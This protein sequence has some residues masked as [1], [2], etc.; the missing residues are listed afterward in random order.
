MQ[1]CYYPDILLYKI[2]ISYQEEEE[3]V[4]LSVDRVETTEDMT[5]DPSSAC[6][7]EEKSKPS[8]SSSKL[9][10][11]IDG[12]LKF[13]SAVSESRQK[14]NPSLL[15]NAFL[16]STLPS[17]ISKALIS[18]SNDK[19]S[20]STPC[21]T[22]STSTTTTDQELVR[23]DDLHHDVK[24]EAMDEP[25]NCVKIEDIL[26]EDLDND[27]S[28]DYLPPYERK[29]MKNRKLSS[30][31]NASSESK[32]LTKCS[33]EV[34]DEDNHSPATGVPSSLITP[35]IKSG[36]NV[37]LFKKRG[38]KRR[39][40]KAL[41]LVPNLKTCQFCN[42]QFDQ[43]KECSDHMREGACISALFC[44]ICIRPFDSEED[45][46]KHILSHG[47]SPDKTISFDCN[48]CQ[49][50]YR[51]RAGY[52]KHFRMGTC[53]KR[54][55]F[56]DG[57]SG[58]FPCSLC[59]TVF[60]NK[61]YLKL[62]QYKVHENP[63]DQHYCKDCGKKFHSFLGFQRHKSARPCTEPLKCRVCGKTYKSKESFKIH[64][65]HHKSEISGEMFDCDVCARSYM[66]QTALTKHKL[67][68]TGVKPYKCETCGKEFA[69]RYQV[70]DHARTH[71]GERPF[72]CKLCGSAFSNKGHLG[73]HI[74]SHENGTLTR[75][76]RPKKISVPDGSSSLK[77]A[78][79][80]TSGAVGGLKLIDIAS[81]LQT[82]D[83]QTVQ[84]VDGQLFESSNSG[85]PPMI[86]HTDNNTIIFT[87]SWPQNSAELPKQ[88]PATND[89][90][91]ASLTSSGI[92][93]T[94]KIDAI[95]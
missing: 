61:D 4:V 88:Q 29:L 77:I 93:E 20:T 42:K 24:T 35:T 31:L 85:N 11:G 70:K 43:V 91:S 16:Q 2:F 68:H 84:V 79:V 3:P 83:G 65:K 14:I 32:I 47:R 89:V 51:T 87:E 9:G 37:L 48:D 52:V 49:R 22:D 81:T 34:S 78:H 74:R 45:L 10:T 71:T 1:F 26:D 5:G 40:D 67:S 7:S 54:D 50:S 6:K 46:E 92:N 80:E 33:K 38:R 13:L 39:W 41:G 21:T 64:M 57:K 12:G 58:D 19:I 53:S 15:S 69:M 56:E 86:I 66:T 72:L 95:Q 25:L 36:S 55:E 75:R 90:S 73:R 76:G 17:S 82:I 62:H 28:T 27:M 8:L 44:Y 18:D 30:I 63:K 94:N 60:S 23:I 59:R